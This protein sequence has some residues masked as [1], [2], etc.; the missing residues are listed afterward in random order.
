MEEKG[1]STSSCAL[2]NAKRSQ[3]QQE[4]KVS[5]QPSQVVLS[6][7]MTCHIVLF[8]YLFL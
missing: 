6:N 2:H 1:I 7:L 4:D 5:E 3:Q 8:I